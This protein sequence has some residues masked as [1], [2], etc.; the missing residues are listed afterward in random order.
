M[1][2]EK[3]NVHVLVMTVEEWT[4]IKPQMMAESWCATHG[5]R[6]V[7]VAFCTQRARAKAAKL[8]RKRTE[9]SYITGQQQ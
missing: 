8:C 7:S 9:D 6:D 1:Q 3:N 4:A 2:E 5:E